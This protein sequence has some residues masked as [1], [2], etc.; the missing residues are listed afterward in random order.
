M[1]LKYDEEV[2][3]KSNVIIQMNIPNDENLN[4][5]KKGSNFNWC[6]KSLFK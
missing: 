3:S 6:F 5:L 4:K 1:L 2:I